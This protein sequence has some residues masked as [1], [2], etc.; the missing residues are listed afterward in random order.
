LLVQSLSHELGAVLNAKT[1]NATFQDL[2][3]GRKTLD[4]SLQ[5]L[6]TTANQ[7]LDKVIRSEQQQFDQ[8]SRINEEYLAALQ[9]N[10][11]PRDRKNNYILRGQV[12]REDTQE[13]LIGLL[14]K[15]TDRDVRYDDF[16]GLAI[17]DQDGRFE[18]DF[19]NKD[20]KESGENLPEVILEVGIDRQT[21]LYKTDTPLAIRP[22]EPAT[23]T[24]VLPTEQA[25]IAQHSVA[26][27]QQSAVD[28]VQTVNRAIAFTQYQHLQA[29]AIGKALKT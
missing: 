24:L 12:L 21:T 23:M 18:I 27:A 19:G 28:R 22:Q 16:L 11:T 20:F 8:E 13:P 4:Q 5:Q 29:Q 6:A 15:A 7:V 1:L 14:V 2:V 25:D 3:T 10:K 9:Q 26:Q 17:T